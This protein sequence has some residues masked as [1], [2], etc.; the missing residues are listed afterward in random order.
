ML[1]ELFR[2]AAELLERGESAVLVTVVEAEGAPREAGARMLVFPDG[3]I[4]GTVGGGALEQHAIAKALQLL[5]EGRKTLLETRDLRDLGMLC[6]GHTVLFYEVLQ[7][8]P[9]LLIFGA[10]HV[11]LLLARVARETTPWRIVLADDREERLSAAPA[12]VETRFLPEYQGLPEIPGKVYAVV[13]TESHE[14]DFQV[15]R[16]L[17]R[18][19]PGP[20][21]LGLLGSRAK[22]KEIK[23]KLLALGIPKERVEALRCPVGLPLGGKDPG[24]LVL[25]VLSEILAFH[26]G[27]LPLVQEKFARE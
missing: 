7:A 1:G 24:S 23:E 5:W 17:L 6:G 16:E 8:P 4:E 12:G 11:G 9:V 27:R 10:G 22:A 20:A 13:A 18:G 26:H 14:K 3:R 2:R 25:S 15:V 21:Y 19:E